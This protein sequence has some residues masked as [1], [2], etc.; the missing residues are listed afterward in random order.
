[1]YRLQGMVF[2]V[3]EGKFIDIKGILMPFDYFWGEK[4]YVNVTFDD[5]TFNKNFQLYNSLKKLYWS[6][7]VRDEEFL[8]EYINYLKQRNKIN[9]YKKI[10]S[11]TDA[12]IAQMNRELNLEYKSIL[13][14]IED[15]RQSVD[16]K[17][18]NDMSN[19]Q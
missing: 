11:Y 10:D 17:Q 13:D 6:G 7:E 8:N 14:K 3:I 2:N 4:I 16:A 19:V 9:N 15:I 1:M 5:E 12:E 18:K